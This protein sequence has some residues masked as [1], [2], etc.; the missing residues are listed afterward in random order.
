MK[1]SMKRSIFFKML[2]SYVVLLAFA[3]SAVAI[4]IYGMVSNNMQKQVCQERVAALNKVETIVSHDLSA[5]GQFV[6]KSRQKRMYYR[7]YQDELMSPFMDIRDELLWMTE[8]NHLVSRAIF[9]DEQMIFMGADIYQGQ[10]A[11]KILDDIVG[12]RVWG[13]TN[14][15][16]F[17]QHDSVRAY[18]AMPLQFSVGT[19]LS[20]SACFIFELDKGYIETLLSSVLQDP[21]AA[22]ELCCGKTTVLQ[23]GSMTLF[24]HQNGVIETGSNQ[25]LTVRCVITQNTF[26]DALKMAA[27]SIVLLSLAVFTIGLLL[28]VALMQ[29]NYAPLRPVINRLKELVEN[30]SNLTEY[31]VMDTAITTLETSNRLLRQNQNQLERERA[32]LQLLSF[33]GDAT[34]LAYCNLPDTSCYLCAILATEEEQMMNTQELLNR[35]KIPGIEQIDVI[36]MNDHYKILLVCGK[37]KACAQLKERAV[38]LKNHGVLLFWGSIVD[39]PG[40]LNLSYYRATDAFSAQNTSPNEGSSVAQRSLSCPSVELESLR[41]AL[42][43]RN[44]ARIQFCIQGIRRCLNETRDIFA[45]NAIFGMFA[46]IVQQSMA[47]IHLPMQWELPSPRTGDNQAYLST[48]IQCVER[49]EVVILQRLENAAQSNK[50]RLRISDLLACLERRFADPGF[51]LKLLADEYGTSVS[52][53]SHFFKSRTGVTLSSRLDALRINKAKKLLRTTGAPLDEIA[54][55][56]GYSNASSFIRKFRTLEGMTPGEYRR[57]N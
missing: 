6:F 43:S 17:W 44:T 47:E 34:Q 55:A 28:I 27:I 19:P 26:R 23:G 14:N 36:H 40:Q 4:A 5:L 35:M 29:H 18:V 37:M 25:I 15:M 45:A 38:L 31:E 9:F 52:N 21:D 16:L 33:G 11:Q 42:L 30:N 3:L 13:Q 20:R 56:V 22:W 46:Y 7:K 50:P 12:D 32:L 41:N 2:I 51:S 57:S 10:H 8:S 54:L 53:L 49:I 48:L 39:S 24:D 1:Y